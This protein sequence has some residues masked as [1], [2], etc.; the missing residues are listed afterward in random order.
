M[1]CVYDVLFEYVWVL[2]NIKFENKFTLQWLNSIELYFSEWATLLKS[3]VFVSYV[4]LVDGKLLL[5]SNASAL[6]SDGGTMM[7]PMY[8]ILW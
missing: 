1:C 4:F 7:I 3:F 8:I 6:F 5:S 2:T